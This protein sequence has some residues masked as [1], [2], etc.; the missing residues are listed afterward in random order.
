[1]PPERG[2]APAS[3]AIV[4]APHSAMMPPSTQHTRIAPGACHCAATVAGTRKMPLP[5]VTPTETATV[6]SSPTERGMRSPQ[7]SA[8]GESFVDQFNPV[9]HR[10]RGRAADVMQA[11]D[12]GG[13][14]ELG[15]A[16]LEGA[17][18]GL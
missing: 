6:C 8:T 15:R 12:V 1:M 10:Q 5:M 17:H 4:S 7:A 2:S 3:S 11:T 9:A 13:G 14:D 18:L 16:R